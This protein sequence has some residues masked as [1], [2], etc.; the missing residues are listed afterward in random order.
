MGSISFSVR[1]AC[2]ADVD[3]I[4]RMKARLAAAEDAAFAVRAT[5]A[6]WL[7][8]GFGATARFR[9]YVAQCDDA[10]VGMV[11]YS[12]RA[13]TG[14]R[15]PALYIQDL[16]V[17]HKYRRHGI[18]RALLARVAADAVALGSP[19]IELTMHARNPAREFYRRAGFEPVGDCVHYIAAE[20]GLSTLVRGADVASPAVASDGPAPGASLAAAGRTR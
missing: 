8:D 5:H 12:E 7:R 20:A 18:A 15:Q 4:I 17:E 11:I 13:Y 10:S 19:M 3:S 6:D 14:W 9:I 2:A 1:P 16:F